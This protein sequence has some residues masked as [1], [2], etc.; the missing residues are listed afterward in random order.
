MRMAKGRETSLHVW[1]GC[2]PLDFVISSLFIFFSHNYSL[3][4]RVLSDF[5]CPRLLKVLWRIT[6]EKLLFFLGE[7]QL[8]FIMVF[9][10]IS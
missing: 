5:D 3:F 10:G 9:G 7:N 2:F 8:H 4:P 6:L 1:S